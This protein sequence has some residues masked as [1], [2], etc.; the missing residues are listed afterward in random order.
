MTPIIAI[1]GAVDD[2]KTI[3]LQNNYTKAIENAKAIPIV[4][5]YTEK[6]EVL[7]FYM[8]LCDGVLF[9]GGCDIEPKK[10]GEQTKE[11]C[12][13]IQLYRDELEFNF[14]KKAIDRKKPI[15]DPRMV[16]PQSNFRSD[17]CN[18]TKDNSS[19]ITTMTSCVGC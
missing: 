12:G 5:P 18:G 7:D 6:E 8:D 11:S 4:I 3:T 17:L 1:I 10:F 9:S 15:M 2:D 13:K 19:S 16:E 14:F